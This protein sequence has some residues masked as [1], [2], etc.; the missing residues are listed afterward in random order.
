M[1]YDLKD[2]EIAITLGKEKPDI[3]TDFRI[4]DSLFFG[5][6]LAQALID[7]GHSKKFKFKKCRIIRPN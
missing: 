4:N 5:D 1:P 7:A 3:W 2:G 6:G